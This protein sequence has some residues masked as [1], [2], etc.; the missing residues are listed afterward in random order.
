MGAITSLTRTTLWL[1]EGKIKLSGVTNKVVTSY[2]NERYQNVVVWN[3]PYKNDNPMQILRTEITGFVNEVLDVRAGFQVIV[4]YVIRKVIRGA[5]V[6]VIIHAP[7]GTPLIGTED[8]D[9]NLSLLE[10][11]SPGK[12]RAIV[13]LP[14]DWL[15]AGMY[16]LR[17]HSGVV[18]QAMFDNIEALSFELVETGDPKLRDHKEAYFL[19]YL[20]WKQ[21]RID[22]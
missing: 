18:F 9:T 22:D 17:L 13:T 21:E 2:L 20:R 8:V 10:R 14:G 16:M 4:E 12:Y 1:D 11:R 3:A 15:S 6:S 19:P 7:D 5:V